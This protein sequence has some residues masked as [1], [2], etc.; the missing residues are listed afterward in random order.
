MHAIKEFDI[1]G[2]SYK[3]NTIWENNKPLYRATDIGKILGIKNIR[4]SLRIIPKDLKKIFDVKTSGGIQRCSYLTDEGLKRLIVRTRSSTASQIAAA[5]GIEILDNFLPCIEAEWVNVV[6]QVFK[7]TTEI[8]PQYFVKGYRID[9][10]LPEYRLAL[11]CDESHH[12]APKNK[13]LD[14]TRQNNL[15]RIL[16]CT[17]LRYDPLN[18]DIYDFIGK[19]HAHII[20]SFRETL[21]NTQRDIQQS[22]TNTDEDNQNNQDDHQEKDEEN[23]NLDQ[24]EK[25]NRVASSRIQKYSKDGKTL[26]EVYDSFAELYRKTEGQFTYDAIK[27]SIKQN[28]SYKDFRWAEIDNKLPKNTVQDLPETVKTKKIADKTERLIALLSDDQSKIINVYPDQLSLLN[29]LNLPATSSLI[30]QSMS[31]KHRISGKY[32]ARRWIDCDEQLKAD[33]LKENALPEPR[34]QNNSKAVLQIDKMGRVVKTI[35]SFQK[36]INELAIGAKKGREILSDLNNNYMGYYYKFADESSSSLES[37]NPTDNQV[38]NP[39]DHQDD[40]QNDIEQGNESSNVDQGITFVSPRSCNRSPHLLKEKRQ[41]YKPDGTLVKTYH[42]FSDIFLDP[43]N[44]ISPSA[45]KL[46]IKKNRPCK[47]GFVWLKLPRDYPDDFVQDLKNPLIL[48]SENNK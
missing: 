40:H 6:M 45:L 1:D 30:R 48:I 15:S 38:D 17:F 4:E 14:K 28:T 43:S 20:K 9:L 41:K 12:N 39:N 8:L 7:D 34:F 37:E 26:I 13:E 2:A 35:S 29:F 19:I 23:N 32:Y 21:N 25:S 33:F 3:V 47:N 46:A 24:S 27:R 44:D 36:F 11:E 42:S 16:N 10:Y 5:L 22:E 31:R 18:D